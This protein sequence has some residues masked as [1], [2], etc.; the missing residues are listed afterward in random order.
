MKDKVSLSRQEEEGKGETDEVAAIARKL[1]EKYGDKPKEKKD[2]IQ[3]LIDI[4]YGYD[5]EDSFIDNSEA[6][7]EFVPASITTKFGGFYVNAG[8]LQFRQTSDADIFTTEEKTLEATKKRKLSSAQDKPRKRR[9]ADGNPKLSSLSET[10]PD[11]EMKIK[12]KKKALRTLSVTSMLKKFQREKEMER[13][14]MEKV[15]QKAAVIMNANTIPIFPADAGRGGGSGLTDPLLSLIGSTNDHALIQAAST[16]DFDIDLDSLLDV[17]EETLLPKSLPQPAAETQPIQTKTDNQTKLSV[18]ADGKAQTPN[19]KTSP[20]LKPHPE[21]MQLQ[22]EA[23]S[24]S[25]HQCA[26]LPEGLPPG[27]EA[28]IGK[29]LVAAKTS[30]GESKLKFFNPVINSILIDI[31]LQCREQG[32]QLRSRVYTHLSPFLPCS[33]DTLLKRVRKLLTTRMEEEEEEETPDVEDPLQKL[34]EAIGRSMP[35]QITCFNETCQ[36]YEQVK[37]SKATEE[38]CVEEKGGKRKSPKRLFKWNEEIRNFLGQMLREKLDKYVKERKGGQEMEEYLKTVL[39]NEIKALWPKGWMQSRVLISESRKLLGLFNSLPV[40]RAKSERKQ[41]SITGASIL[42][43][44]CDSLQGAALKKGD[45]KNVVELDAGYATPTES[46]EALVNAT[47]AC[48]PS[49]L[50]LLADEALAREQTLTVSQ[51]LI[52]AAVAKYKPSVQRSS[53]GVGIKSP[54]PPPQSSPVDFPESRV[55]QGSVAQLLQAPD[56]RRV[57]DTDKV[58]V[59]SDDDDDDDDDIIIQ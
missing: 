52:A 43:G 56:N 5:E 26:P 4:G 35:E 24:P 54:P 59:I 27:L 51:E 10:G 20:Q 42:S 39:D 19:I 6:Y 47:S 8:V 31:E 40:K 38:D 14:K 18:C 11:K 33:K 53:F 32:S 58:L 45:A 28:S 37:T 36:A 13:Q 15:K 57:D 30:E 21:H 23:S 17:T 7:D 16:V 46:D 48:T 34:K 55:F 22:S 3:D 12:K 29:L 49:L 25:T 41:S 50:A 2:R 9:R 1:D 44:G